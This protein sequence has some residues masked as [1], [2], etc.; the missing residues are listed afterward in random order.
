MPKADPGGPAGGKKNT[1]GG[2][3][4]RRHPRAA[5]NGHTFLNF[6]CCESL[7]V[8]EACQAKLGFQNSVLK[9]YSIYKRA[10]VDY[11]YGAS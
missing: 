4:C 7:I 8:K 10:A 11:S 5:Y 6:R 3:S 9:G 1:Q 2:F